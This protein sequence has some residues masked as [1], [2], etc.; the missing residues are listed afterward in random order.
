LRLSVR[1][2]LVIGL[3]TLVPLLVTGVMTSRMARE[4]HVEQARQLYERQ[5]DG[6]SIY[7]STWIGDLARAVRLATS[8]WE[9]EELDAAQLEGLQRVLYL[10]FES[11]NAVWTFDVDGKALSEPTRRTDSQAS[12]SGHQRVDDARLERFRQE[13]PLTGALE[14]GLALGRIYRLEPGGPPLVA[15]AVA[16]PR[17]RV[18]VGLE[19]SLLEVEQQVQNQAVPGGAAVLLDRGGDE[20][21]GEVGLVDTELARS[22]LGQVEG[23]L[24]YE[25]ADGPVLAGFSSVRGT[26]WTAVVA[27][28]EAMATRGGDQ[29]ASRTRFVYVIALLLVAAMGLVSARQIARPVTTLRRAAERLGSGTYEAVDLSAHDP[30]AELEDLARVFNATSAQLAENQAEIASKNEEIQAWNEELQARVEARTA[31]L[32]QSQDRLVESSRLA[33]VAQMGAGLAHELNNP[34]AGI[35]GLAQLMRAKDPEDPLLHNIEEQARRCARIL[36]SLQRLTEEGAS[37]HERLDLAELVAE[38]EPLVRHGFEVAGVSLEL[39]LPEAL[40]IQGDRARLAQ[41]LVQLLR[42]VRSQQAPGGRLRVRGQVDG[43]RVR[44]VLTP[45]GSTRSGQDDWLASGMGFWIARHVLREHG[46]HL[47]TDASTQVLVLPV[48][49]SAG[50]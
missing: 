36:Q 26:E 23:V 3:S 4:H 39:E 33:A 37:E 24:R 2:I 43:E 11:V 38:I 34:V 48:L 19:V 1:L 13:V 25:G 50:A 16:G 8:V 49:A 15:L 20:V 42:S 5:A 17:K 28:P 32:K 35:L 18:V 14:E 29:I 44:L 6:L 30:V 22:F 41:A 31:E 45:Q 12:L 40:P 21:L 7:A 46:G 9:V 47:E 27:V 10:Q